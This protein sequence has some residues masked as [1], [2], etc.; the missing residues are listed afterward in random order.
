ME[1]GTG[2]EQQIIEDLKSALDAGFTKVIV[3]YRGDNAKEQANQM[4]KFADKI[5]PK[6]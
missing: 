6:L 2:S 3:R 5:I 1:V 4:E